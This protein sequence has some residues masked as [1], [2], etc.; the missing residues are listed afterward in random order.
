MH[1]SSRLAPSLLV[2]V[3]LLTSAWL[4]AAERGIVDT[5]HSP[6]VKQRSVDLDA[7]RWTN[8]FWADKFK[9]A[10]EVMVPNLWRILNDPAQ[11]HAWENFRIVAGLAQGEFKGTPWYD[12]DL[13]KTLEAAAYVY[14]ITKDPALDRMLDEAAAVIAKAQAPD[15]YIS[16]FIQ[17]GHGQ[18][19]WGE[20]GD[21]PYFPYSGEK[22]W[23]SPKRHELYNMGHLLTLGCIHHRA[24]GKTTFLNIARKTADHLYSVFHTRD[25][26]L[27]HFCFNPS[28]IMGLVELYRVTGEKK[29]LELAGIFVDMRGS[30]PGGT[31]ENQTRT[32]F[33]DEKEAVGHAVTAPYLYAGAA[34]V[35]AET[36]EKALWTALE[37]IWK[38]VAYQKMY[39]TGG[40]SAIHTGVTPQGDPTTESF[41]REYEL[42][43]LTAY[44]ETCAN[45]AFGMWNWRMLGLTGEARYADLLETVLYNGGLSGLSADGTHFC[46]SNPLR[47]Y[48][49]ETK[50]LKNDTHTRLTY[51]GCFC[52]PPNVVRIIASVGGWAYGVSNEGVWVNLYGGNELNT[53]LPDGTKVRLTQETD[54]PWDGRV[55]L[56]VQSTTAKEYAVMLRIPDWAEGTSVAVNG[57]P[58]AV[59]ITPGQY[60]AVKRAWQVGDVITLDLPLRTR[61]VGAH[62]RVEETRGQ[63]AVQRGPVVYCV[64]GTDLPAGVNLLDVVIPA[65]IK[66]TP[67]HQPGFIGGITTLTGPALATQCL[68]WS[69]RLYADWTPPQT[70]QFELKLIPY[71][72]W[73]NRGPASMSV[74]LPVA[75]SPAAK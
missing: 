10:H 58:A 51:L 22:R 34:D 44:N 18:F 1:A 55:K 52:C 27:A 42:P 47:W 24:T 62:P 19:T 3:C 14:A 73:N 23:Q 72:A 74:W 63:V 25:P 13:Y 21:S 53:A 4:G 38:N 30:Q 75:W 12:G 5:T 61:L 2:A 36:G 68:D 71:Y 64:E 65:G 45:L 40:T 66:F 57:Q 41:G 26:R 59:T 69:N 35:Y 15:G 20:G 6:F 16:T 60:A 11:S 17:I 48:G 39:L 70:R 56:V 49:R 43:N 37:R 67:Q 46:Y 32:P 31:E 9:L 8:G 7:V 28:N 54:Y 50:L 29:Y 33:R